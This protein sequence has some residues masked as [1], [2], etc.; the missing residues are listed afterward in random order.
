MYLGRVV[1]EGPARAVIDNPQHPYTRALI[2]VVL[3]ADP[4]RRGEQQIIAGEIPDAT[5]IPSGC[6]F[7]PRC[8]VRLESCSELDQPLGQA[9]GAAPGHRA[10]CVHVRDVAATAERAGARA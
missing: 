8:P 2:S 9:R 6:R 1:E 3:D 4:R 7:H 5:R 10:A